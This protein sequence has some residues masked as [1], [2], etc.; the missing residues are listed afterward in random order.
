MMANMIDTFDRFAQPFESQGVQHPVLLKH[1]QAG[2]GPAVLVLHE[3]PGLTNDC[4]AF[5]DRLVNNGFSV[6]LPVLFGE[7]GQWNLPGGLWHVCIHQEFRDLAGN[8]SS[9]IT[10]WLR[11][12]ARHIRALPEHRD[13]KGI[14][15]VGLCL[16]GGFV[17]SLVLEDA[18]IAPVAA[19]PALPW[20][21]TAANRQNIGL[22]DANLPKARERVAQ[23][24]LLGL[25][26]EEDLICPRERFDA[27]KTQF[28]SH[29]QAHTITAEH[30]I[31]DGVP[32]SM[33]Q[34]K[35]HAVLTDDYAN[36][37][38]TPYACTL[39]AFERVIGF[40]RARLI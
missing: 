27:L 23:T 21:L 35:P 14:G 30:R 18:V 4:L 5:A 8:G 11:V 36:S 40:L 20:A 22:H 34:L 1:P 16:T 9:P 38:G 31:R 13:S 28:G 12:L 25:R 24:G 6:Y 19:E 39:E 15:A 26:F 10:E 33:L 3:L 32:K 2:P 37:D 17:L 7:P 29:F